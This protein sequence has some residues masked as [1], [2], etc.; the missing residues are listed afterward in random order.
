MR[1]I[2]QQ[3]GVALQERKEWA[4][5]KWYKPGE[6]G[7]REVKLLDYACGTG[8]IT[9]ALGPWVTKI[10]GI[11]VSEN[12]VQ[13]YNEEAQ[14]AGLKPDEVYAIVGDLLADEVPEELKKPEYYEFDIAVIGLGFHHFENPVTAIQRLTERLKADTGVLMIIDFLPFDTAE[15]G[16]AAHTIK[17]SGFTRANLEKLHRIARMQKF[18]FSIVDD[19]AVMELQEGTVKR[20]LFI[21][22][23]M[24]EPTAWGKFSNWVYGLQMS[25][26]Q[27]SIL[28]TRPK[29][30]VPT[31]LGVTGQVSGPGLTAGTAKSDWHERMGKLGY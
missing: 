22:R 14:A 24:K 19:P 21:S 23:A 4:G 20:T 31:Q 29:D 6:I 3:I 10:I 27:Q 11:D 25:A 1:T 18:S 28:Q 30:K 13:K 5:V 9:K 16:Q 7:G 12:M 26:A 2:S 15:H 17:H 8:S